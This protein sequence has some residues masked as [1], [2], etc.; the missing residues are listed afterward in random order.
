MAWGLPAASANAAV[1]RP[2]PPIAVSKS[3]TKSAA[4]AVSVPA[5]RRAANATPSILRRCAGGG[6]IV[7]S[8]SR[9]RV[10]PAPRCAAASSS[11]CSR[12][13]SGCRARCAGPPLPSVPLPPPR[14]AASAAAASAAF[15][16]ISWRISLARGDSSTVADSAVDVGGVRPSGE[17]AP[18][19]RASPS[20]ISAARARS[21]LAANPPRVAG[22]AVRPVSARNARASRATAM[23]PSAPIASSSARSAAAHALPAVTSAPGAPAP[24][25]L[26]PVPR[27][28]AAHSA[29]ATASASICASPA[30]ARTPAAASAGTPPSSAWGSTPAVVSTLARRSAASSPPPS[31]ASSHPSS[32][33]SWPSASDS[34]SPGDSS[35]S[36]AS[37]LSGAQ[38]SPNA[39]SASVRPLRSVCPPGVCRPT[40]SDS[41]VPS[42]GTS[43]VGSPLAYSASAPA[44][45][46]RPITRTP[47][48]T[49]S[50]IARSSVVGI[51]W[52]LPG[53][54]V[55]T[56][57]STPPD[58]VG[59]RLATARP[60]VKR[61]VPSLPLKRLSAPC[62][63]HPAS[64]IDVKSTR[65]GCV[66]FLY[67]GVAC[68]ARAAARTAPAT[69][70]RAVP[71][72]AWKTK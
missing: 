64:P 49:P 20:D 60:S 63:F 18:A 22:P 23:A 68:D 9:G 17:R 35:A 37:P 7:W 69:S 14:L 50:L 10:P 38:R 39:F 53:T 29:R 5:G 54:V 48:N 27:C 34:S 44:P 25:P 26:R 67:F 31:P 47:G 59:P 70:V 66:D 13:P 30:P 4:A 19:S 33:S 55:W 72:V 6:I 3:R 41:G 2:T 32:S 58:S 71:V 21:A 52:V 15:S 12:R 65:A 8:G 40:A 11:N 28:A 1:T 46:R 56:C 36:A 62:C 61:T 42:S 57:T 24:A 45:L 43:S 51:K 16:A